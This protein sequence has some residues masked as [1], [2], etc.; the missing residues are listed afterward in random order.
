[1]NIEYNNKKW[2]LTPIYANPHP[3]LRRHLWDDL[4]NIKPNE[5]E[6]WGIIGDFNDITNASEKKKG[7]APFET[8][9]GRHFVDWIDRTQLI[10]VMADGPFFTWCGP[11]VGHYDRVF[12]RLVRLLCNGTWRLE[13]HEA[14]MSVLPRSYSDHHLLLLQLEGLA[15]R[16]ELKPF[17]FE[18]AWVTHS[19][20]NDF[21]RDNWNSCID[22]KPRV[23]NFT[24]K[25]KVWNKEVFGHIE[26]KKRRILN[27]LRGIQGISDLHGNRFLLNLEKELLEDLN[28]V[29]TQ[30]EILWHQKSRS[31]W[32]IKG[33]KNTRFFHTRTI[34]RRRRNRV[35][36][37]KSANDTWVEDAGE[38]RQMIVSF[39]KQL[40]MDDLVNQRPLR[41]V[42]GFVSIEQSRLN[43]LDALPTL[44]EL[45]R[46][47]FSMGST[48]A[49]GEDGFPALFFQKSWSTVRDS[50]HDVVK[51]V[52]TNG[53]KL[54]DINNT[55][56]VLVP[57]VD[58]P[59]VVS[60]FIPIS[61][62]NVIYKCISKIIVNR[63]KGFLPE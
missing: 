28:L 6:A 57:K 47:L 61:L 40:F 21:V 1:M 31:A 55:L 12:E 27:R 34:I 29:L 20:F 60:Q 36:M 7:G 39:Y 41:V 54:D 4:Y 23:K 37:L 17:R 25:I 24:D 5:S 42:K 52:F 13:F 63:L 46:A 45:K 9:R 10:D 22:W 18:A 11:K 15:P 35:K 14:S 44:D 51:R 49:P 26:R 2:W 58:H 33:D 3:K 19:Q 16:H 50:M 62:C 53:Y 56:I 32:L 30:E 8:S 43:P 48:K 38:I 59:E